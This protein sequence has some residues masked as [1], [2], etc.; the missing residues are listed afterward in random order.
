MTDGRL[1]LGELVAQPTTYER[2]IIAF[3][4]GFFHEKSQKKAVFA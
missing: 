4:C 3:L 2:R 1:H